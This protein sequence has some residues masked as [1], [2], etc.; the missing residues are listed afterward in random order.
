[1][2]DD[3]DLLLRYARERSE[4]AFAELVRRHIDL[5]YSAA[6]RRVG[7]D[8]HRAGEIT[9]EVFLSLARHAGPL[10]RHPVLAAWLHTSTRNAAANLRRA[11]RR[12]EVRAQEALAMNEIEASH[13]PSPEWRQLRPVLDEMVDELTDQDRRAIILRFFEGRSYAELGEILALREEAARMRVGRALD[14]LRGRLARRGI[15][16]TSAALS[17]A[18]AGWAVSAAPH[19]LAA[20][21]TGAVL[22]TAPGGAALTT[23]LIQLMTTTKTVLGLGGAAVLFLIGAAVRD[24][25]AGSQLQAE[26]AGASQAA[27][28]AEAHLQDLRRQARSAEVAPAKAA[29]AGSARG[30]GAAADAFANA[31]ELIANHPEIKGAW[32]NLRAASVG[33]GARN[34]VKASTLELNADQQEKLLQAMA[35]G[36]S[37][38]Q[39]LSVNGRT[40]AFQAEGEPGDRQAALIALLGS[41]PQYQDLVRTFDSR[42]IASDLAAASVDESAP[43]TGLQV[44]Q[45]AQIIASN[46]SSYQQGGAATAAS[47]NWEAVAAQARGL[48]SPAQQAVLAEEAKQVQ[49]NVA[50]RAAT[51]NSAQ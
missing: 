15:S 39:S 31:Q 32:D 18:L 25:L 2:T 36:N 45:I 19:G 37:I 23:G 43:L 40:Y 33:S 50:T 29:A 51:A 49:F 4:A 12:R 24:T 5:V 47:I 34:L 48:L 26:L 14:K 21:V 8:P 7:G 20:S 41:E 10:A 27:R 13:R 11:E 16:S 30:T 38:N 35:I 6:A 9:Q 1:M 44:R 22:T 3:A 17:A 46:S 42:N 28:A